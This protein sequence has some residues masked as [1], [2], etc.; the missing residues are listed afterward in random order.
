MRLTIAL[1]GALMLA[2]SSPA[3]ASAEQQLNPFSDQGSSPDYRS[4][5]T[6]VSP[7]V[8]GLQLQVLQFSDRLQLTNHTGHTV[9]VLGYQDEPYARVQPGGA[10]EVNTSSPAYYLNQSFFATVAVPA[11]A[12]PS[13]TPHWTVID[14]TGELEWHDHRIHWM[15]P[16]PPEK[17]RDRSRRTF[18]FDWKV[19]IDVGA[20]SSTINGQLFWVPESSKVPTAAVVALVVLTL[21]ALVLVVVLRRR[22]SRKRPGG[23]RAGESPPTDRGEQPTISERDDRLREAW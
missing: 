22:R 6:S 13:A 7:S 19:P 5:I 4:L 10:V 23:G 11:S 2:S 16:V 12:T 21:L 1:L 8:P 18:I 9:T 3:N 17:V 15:S 14:R 20:K